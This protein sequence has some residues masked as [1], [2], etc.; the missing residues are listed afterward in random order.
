MGWDPYG[1]ACS[2]YGTA[3]WIVWGYRKQNYSR[4]RGRAAS[5]VPP[6]TPPTDPL[7]AYALVAG[8]ALGDNRML[9][10]CLSQYRRRRFRANVR[11]AH[12]SAVTFDG[13]VFAACFA[14]TQHFDSHAQRADV[15]TDANGNA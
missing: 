14:L 11:A 3:G 12:A 15:C 9:H 7:P 8:G 5:T 1:F 6:G 2:G 10:S 13:L 4:A